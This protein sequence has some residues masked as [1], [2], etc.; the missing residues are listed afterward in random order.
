MEA[1]V[2]GLEAEGTYLWKGNSVAA[3]LSKAATRLERELA[4][5]GEQSQGDVATLHTR[6]DADCDVL[7]VAAGIVL[8]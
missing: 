4:N 2:Q 1:S 3:L 8:F 7:P 5:A 6:G